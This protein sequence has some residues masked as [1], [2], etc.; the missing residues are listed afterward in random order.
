MSAKR[1]TPDKGPPAGLRIRSA[2]VRRGEERLEVRFAASN[3]GDGPLYVQCGIRQILWDGD[4]H[5]VTL[6]F[7][8]RHRR[9]EARHQTVP[10]AEILEPGEK[11]VIEAS[12][13]LRITRL[14]PE[15]DGSFD[16]EI[17]DLSKAR[18]AKLVIG[19]APTSFYFNPK[20]KSILA[21]LKGWGS[22]IEWSG[23]VNRRKRR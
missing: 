10:R 6:C 9:D 3:E 11:K 22:D 14:L 2:R 5:E 4:R 16:F 17:W 18:T 7:S 8:D 23:K 1:K 19:A 13:P 15:D 12:V 20:R 21:Q